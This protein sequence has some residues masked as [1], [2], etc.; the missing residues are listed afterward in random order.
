MHRYRSQFQ[1]CR[2]FLL[3]IQAPGSRVATIKRRSNAKRHAQ[4]PPHVQA[5]ASTCLRGAVPAECLTT[6][7]TG[8]SMLL[9]PLDAQL[10]HLPNPR[11]PLEQGLMRRGQT[12]H[13]AKHNRLAKNRR[14]KTEVRFNSSC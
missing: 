12:P 1:R 4:L 7:A 11:D 2:P 14:A 13:V 10:Y 8:S 6:M 9:I 3:P 5:L